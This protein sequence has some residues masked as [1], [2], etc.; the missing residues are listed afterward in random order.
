MSID[1]AY[2][3]QYIQ[4]KSTSQRSNEWKPTES[5]FTSQ[6]EFMHQL[7]P[8]QFNSKQVKAILY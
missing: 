7:T 1:S 5:P 3:K 2:A 4:K 6:N 8:I